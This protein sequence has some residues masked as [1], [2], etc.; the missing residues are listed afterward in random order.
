MYLVIYSVVNGFIPK[1]MQKIREKKEAVFLKERLICLFTLP[2]LALCVTVLKLNGY[3][4]KRGVLLDKEKS[5]P[6]PLL[7]S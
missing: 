3:R 1:I 4:L 7:S 2:Y 5:E 6:I